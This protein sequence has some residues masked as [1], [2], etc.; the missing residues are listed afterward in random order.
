[1]SMIKQNLANLQDVLNT[2]NALPEAGS[3]GMELPELANPGEAA[4]LLIGNE[5]IDQNGNIVAGTMPD[6]GEITSTMDGINTKSITI[7]EGYTSGGTVSLD[8]TIDNEVDTQ[9]DLIAQIASALEGKAAGGG[10]EA[11]ETCTVI[12]NLDENYTYAVSCFI[13]GV[14]VPAV[15]VGAQ[16]RTVNDCVCGSDIILFSDWE[17]TYSCDKL[18]HIYTKG[19]NTLGGPDA[20]FESRFRID[21][22]AGETATLEFSEF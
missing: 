21:A 20:T 2:I 15:Y 4:D 22:H 5:L 10:G 6:N 9:A 11:L 3:G 19:E 18:T 16:S 14:V 8:G 13:N 7:P 12:L 17:G 1:M